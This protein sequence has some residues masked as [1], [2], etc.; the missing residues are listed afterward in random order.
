MGTLKL[1]SNNMVIATLDCCIW[2]SKEG[3][4][5]AAALPS[6]L[7]AVPNVTAQPQ[8]VYQLHVI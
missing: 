1:Q 8:P 5:W 2:Y 7:L 3:P 4:G 6:L